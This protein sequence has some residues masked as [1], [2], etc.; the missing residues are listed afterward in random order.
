MLMSMSILLLILLNY[1]NKLGYEPRSIAYSATENL[2]FPQKKSSI[3]LRALDFGKN[4]QKRD[5]AYI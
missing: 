3:A 1:E 5:S 4:L 2:Y